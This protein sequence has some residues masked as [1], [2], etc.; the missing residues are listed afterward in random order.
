MSSHSFVISVIS[1]FQD[2][3]VCLGVT[4]YFYIQSCGIKMLV[5]TVGQIHDRYKGILASGIM[6]WANSTIW[7]I[8]SC[9]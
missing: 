9:K 5:M 6:H 1:P 7:T 8:K 3:K 4:P 2:I